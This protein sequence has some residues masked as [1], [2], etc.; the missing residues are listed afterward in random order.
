MKARRA[1]RRRSPASRGGGFWR[2]VF[3]LLLGFT[4]G[5]GAAAYFAAYINELPIPLSPPP[6]RDA[7][8]PAEDSLQRTRREALEFH[9]T[10]LQRREAPVAAEEIESESETELSPAADGAARRFVYYLQLGAFARRDAAEELRGELALSGARTEI[11]AGGGDGG[12]V[13]RVWAG[14]YSSSEAAEEERANLALQGYNRIQLLK[15]AE[16]KADEND[17]E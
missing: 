15:L 17:A 2:G 6:T 13:F 9:E 4:G 11:R 8:R 12:E 14:P 10:L 5:A 1:I 16:R 7:N 3:L